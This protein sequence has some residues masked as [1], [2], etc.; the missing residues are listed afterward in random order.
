MKAEVTQSE[1]SPGRVWRTPLRKPDAKTRG[2]RWA[3]GVRTRR[4]AST[5]PPGRR[6]RV[7]TCLRLGAHCAMPTAA[8]D[9]TAA[10][11][12]AVPTPCASRQ[13]GSTGATR[14]LCWRIAPL[15]LTRK[16][17]HPQLPPPLTCLRVRWPGHVRPT[18]RPLG[19]SL[20]GG[21][22]GLPRAGMWSRGGNQGVTTHQRGVAPSTSQRMACCVNAVSNFVAA[23][24]RRFRRWAYTRD[25][26]ALRFPPHGVPL[27]R[28]RAYRE[29]R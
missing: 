19:F 13:Q 12:T 24:R 6:G 20:M 29:D 9:V 2:A 11:G 27:N 15:G 5:C 4:P 14:T 21:G 22:D 28:S 18:R 25:S 1:R 16:P 17:R 8:G 26:C 7:P 10:S 3:G 23:T